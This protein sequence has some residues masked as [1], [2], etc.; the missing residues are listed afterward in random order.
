[1]PQMFAQFFVQILALYK[2]FRKNLHK[3][4]RKFSMDPIC[5]RTIRYILIYDRC[6]QLIKTMK[7]R[8]GHAAGLTSHVEHC[9]VDSHSHGKL[10]R[11][12]VMCII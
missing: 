8:N 5:T 9:L 6:P 7:C 1:M 2:F 4:R 10:L 12:S 3:K 11:L